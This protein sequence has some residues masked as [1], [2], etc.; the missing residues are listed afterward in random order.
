MSFAAGS[1]NRPRLHA[2]AALRRSLI[3]GES[4]GRRSERPQTPASAPRSLVLSALGLQVSGIGGAIGTVLRGHIAVRGSPPQSRITAVPSNTPKIMGDRYAIQELLQSGGMASVYRARDLVTDDLVAVKSFD[5]DRHLP[6][7]EREA[8]WREVESLRNLT[9]PHIV[10][11]RDSGEDDEGR[12]FVVLDLMKHDLVQER[13]QDGQAFIG[14]DDFADLVILPLLDALAF[15]HESGIAHRD[16]KPANILIADDGSV[17]L[18]DFSISK[19]KRTLQPRVTLS[20]FMSPPFAP[21]E[22]DSGSFSYARDVYSIGALCI[23]GMCENQLC[24]H[25]DVQRALE[26]A[27]FSVLPQVVEIVRKAI[28]LNPQNRYQNAA[29]I[30]AELSRVQNA[31]RQRWI[32]ADRARC[33]ISM[34]HTARDNLLA[35]LETESEPDVHS[36]VERDMNADTTIGRYIENFGQM[37]ERVRKGQYWLFGGSFKYHIAESDRGYST[38]AVINAFRCDPDFLQ[39]RRDDCLPSPLTMALDARTGM[40]SRGEALDILHTALDQ[41]DSDRTEEKR[42]QAQT[43]LFDV[44]MRVLQAKLQY[45]R[46]QA[47]PVQFTGSSV[48]GTFVTLMTASDLSNIE[49]GENWVIETDDGYR[50]RGE[51]WDTGPDALVLN[52]PGAL[53][54]DIPEVGNA[55]LDLYALRV[56][57][58]R[59]RAAIDSVR[60]GTCLRSGLREV[61]LRPY[62]VASPANEGMLAEPV[63]AMLDTSKQKAV[64][65]CVNADD[66]V[67]VEG[68]PGTGK[69]QFIVGLILQVLTTNPHARV[70]LASQ[71]HIAIDN[72]LERLG[73]EWSG[74]GL[75]RIAREN[76]RSVGE[77]SQQYLVGPQ[78]AMWRDEVVAA[79][80]NGLRAWAESSGVNAEDLRSASLA[81]QLSA[82]DS[83]IGS[84]RERVKEEDERKQGLPEL[85][86]ELSSAEF[87]MESDRVSAELQ[88]LRDQLDTEKKQVDRLELELRGL[89]ADAD[90]VLALDG[91]GKLEWSQTLVAAMPHAEQAERVTNIQSQWFDRLGSKRGLIGPLL[92]RA[93]VVACTCLGLAAIEDANEIAFDLCIIDEASKATAMEACVPMAR[94]KKWV[95]VG[96]SKQL[97]PFQEEVLSRPEL[98]EYFELDEPEAE[99]SAFERLRRLLPDDSRVMLTTQYRMVEPIGRLVSECFYEGQL[100]SVR[101]DTDESLCRLTNRA[102]SWISTR[103]LRNRGEQRA[104]TSFVNPEEAVK[105]CDL[106]LDLD[107]LLDE[108]ESKPGRSVL[109]LSGYAAQVQYLNRRIAHI[110][111]QLRH[112]IPECCTIDRVQGREA[113]A[114]F[115]S[116]TRSN[117]DSRSGFLRELER[118]NVALSRALDLLVIVG[119][120]EFVQ[121]APQAQPL[122]RVLEHIRKWPSE[123]FIAPFEEQS[124]PGDHS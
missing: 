102:V 34:T 118:I 122:Q 80:T 22:P 52:C 70:L 14:W 108:D 62:D 16:V 119:D 100:E 6:E 26:D 37:N 10:R 1:A 89:R 94:A 44:W 58:D 43:A 38:F 48:D 60:T 112:L 97:P 67:L 114:V 33:S 107:D 5:T 121:R 25:A 109:V 106:L 123:C 71:T 82:A 69:T 32:V 105:I 103:N 27:E 4:K 20:E 104:G 15:A 98:R 19:L 45:E 76:S 18:A 90:Q 116:V 96:D 36:F 74:A 54:N 91:S 81:R 63:L 8:F 30:S 50:I 59:Q 64:R 113:D 68:P 51:V 95:L 11:M 88:D 124:G 42:R 29:L 99:E 47:K 40:L 12:F 3:R 46:D 83:R 41:Y 61:L 55:R 92:E 56:A 93:S 72:A 115:F 101:K 35:E 111:P 117:Q 78:M 24:D 110:R 21:P 9:H 120:D 39:R 31:R 53:L 28:E 13:A 73:K 17:R 75:L 77:A 85:K 57:V 65:K 79:A 23:W 49:L 87:E 7:I 86:K 66:L 2:G 84:L